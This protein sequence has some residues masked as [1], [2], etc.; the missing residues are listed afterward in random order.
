MEAMAAAIAEV[1][2]PCTRVSAGVLA[3][4]VLRGAEQPRTVAALRPTAQV[5]QQL[6]EGTH[7][8]AHEPVDGV[9]LAPDLQVH[10]RLDA[11]GLQDR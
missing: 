9:P 6:V 1:V 11:C 8:V 4:G 2:S 5:G 10:V 3:A 7:A